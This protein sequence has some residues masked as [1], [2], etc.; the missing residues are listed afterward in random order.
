MAIMDLYNQMKAERGRIESFLGKFPGYKGYKEKELR[1][2]ADKLLRETLARRVDEQLRRLPD[3]QKQ[4]LSTGQLQWLDDVEGATI[5]LQRFADRM[6]TA[7]YGYAGFFDANRV[8]EGELDRLY[9]FDL[10]LDAQVDEIKASVD[11]MSEAAL[12][13]EKI[14]EAVAR[15]NR[16]AMLANETFERRH[17]VITGTETLRE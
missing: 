8:K 10:A 2:E 3:I 11:T 14:G 5:K 4:L 7:T 6:R 12:S 16:A 1:R 15:L 13:N 9:D 17:D